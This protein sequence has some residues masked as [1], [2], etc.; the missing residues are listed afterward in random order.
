[1]MRH[2]GRIR[3]KDDNRVF[4][5]TLVA[6]VLLSIILLFPY[7]LPMLC[8][9]TAAYLQGVR[10]YESNQILNHFWSSLVLGASLHE[11]FLRTLLPDIQVFYERLAG[12]PGNKWVVCA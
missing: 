12:R 5:F 2:T 6:S 4:I 10:V 8:S 3:Q 7:L 9:S 1:M 11:D